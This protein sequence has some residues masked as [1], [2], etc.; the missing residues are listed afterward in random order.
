MNPKVE[1]TLKDLIQRRIIPESGTFDITEE[2]L[3][4][5]ITTYGGINGRLNG[6]HCEN[7]SRKLAGINLLKLKLARGCTLAQCKEGVVYLISNPAW[8]DHL[9][10][11]MTI[12][13]EK[14][15]KSYQM[16][17]PLKRYAVQNYEFVLDR[18]RVEESMLK[19]FNFHI[20]SGEWIKYSDSVQVINC[21][22]SNYWTTGV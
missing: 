9:K 22:R 14:R 7:F 1:L 15:L 21:V 13:L 16:Y 11:G 17:D 10:I 2:I 4:D 3:S 20:E 18:K 19:T 8:P 5:Y 6:K 12:D